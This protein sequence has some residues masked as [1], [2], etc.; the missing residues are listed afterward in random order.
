MIVR[1]GIMFFN[2][3]DDALFHKTFAGPTND[4]SLEI[5]GGVVYIHMLSI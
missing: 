4:N 5:D 3:Y 1:V 2:V